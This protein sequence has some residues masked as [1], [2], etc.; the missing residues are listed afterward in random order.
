MMKILVTGGKGFIGKNFIEKASSHPLVEDIEILERVDTDESLARKVKKSD[1]IFHFAGINRPK[2]KK[3]FYEGNRDLTERIVNVAKDKEHP[4]SI[5]FTS[6]IQVE[7]NNDYGKS[8]KEAEEILKNYCDTTGGTVYIYRLPNVFGGGSRPNYNSVIA[9]WCYNFTHNLPIRIDD[10]SV[11]LRLVY[12]DDVVNS[13]I[14]CLETK[15]NGCVFKNVG[16]VYHKSLAEIHRI[17]KKF[18]RGELPKNEDAF[19]NALY[20]TYRYYMK[21]T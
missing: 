15:D 14:D 7:R 2:D 17:L 13:F 9:T 3:E 21:G 5:V 18:N 11:E 4:P 20:E 8:K 19:E 1:F 10:P 12:I 16:P 6:S